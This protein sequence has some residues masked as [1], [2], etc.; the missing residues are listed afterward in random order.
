[1]Y[2]A[3]ALRALKMAKVLQARGYETGP[4]MQEVKRLL[5]RRAELLAR[6]R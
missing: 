6:G 5:R 1:M 2:Y 4:V 3:E